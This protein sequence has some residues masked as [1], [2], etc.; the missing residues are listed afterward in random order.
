[1][2]AHLLHD[3]WRQPQQD[4]EL[5]ASS[6]EHVGIRTWQRGDEAPT[7]S[8]MAGGSS[9][10]TPSSTL[11]ASRDVSL[12]ASISRRTFICGRHSRVSRQ[13]GVQED[14]EAEAAEFDS[15]LAAQ[16]KP[17]PESAG[18]F[19]TGA[20]VGATWMGDSASRPPSDMQVANNAK[21]AHACA[22]MQNSL[23][24]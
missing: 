13:A 15:W 11:C 20:L 2:T 16:C 18:E 8:M 7:S 24:A 3:A 17:V 14:W 23:R 9:G 1:M 6:N 19:T 5:A 4:Q 21:H 12:P 10:R 22:Q